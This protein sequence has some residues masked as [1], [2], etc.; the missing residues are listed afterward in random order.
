MRGPLGFL[1]GREVKQFRDA[2]MSY[3]PNSP[4]SDDID[5]DLLRVATPH[6]DML[7]RVASHRDS[8]LTYLPEKWSIGL[9]AW[10]TAAR[11]AK[12]RPRRPAECTRDD[13]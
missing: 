4:R 13:P 5:A 12:L 6:S 8:E 2:S 11:N 9:S 3:L 7:S 10:R 1:F